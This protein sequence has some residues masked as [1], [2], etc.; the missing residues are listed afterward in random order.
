MSQQQA[1]FAKFDW[2][3]F[4][5]R[6]PAADPA[7]IAGIFGNDPDRDFVYSLSVPPSLLG[8]RS[9]WTP[10]FLGRLSIRGRSELNKFLDR[11][12][13][14]PKEDKNRK[15]RIKNLNLLSKKLMSLVIFKILYTLCFLSNLNLFE[16]LNLSLQI[17]DLH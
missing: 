13:P 15:N 8:D 6:E 4:P 17:L 16:Y 10:D 12:S 2:S 11:T 9:F 3:Q 1:P 14:K 5:T 7:F